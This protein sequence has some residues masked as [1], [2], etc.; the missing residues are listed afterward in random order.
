MRWAKLMALTWVGLLA[1][2]KSEQNGQTGSVGVGAC[3][4]QDCARRGQDFL[5]SINDQ[6]VPTYVGAYCVEPSTERAGFA[7]WGV[8]TCQCM[9]ADGTVDV[10]DA[11]VHATAVCG[12]GGNGGG[13][14]GIGGIGSDTSIGGGEPS[15]DGTSGGRGG[16]GGSDA[17]SGSDTCIGG[18]GGGGRGNTLGG[19]AS[20]DWPVPTEACAAWGRGRLACVFP[21]SARQNC[22]TSDPHSCDVVCAQLQQGYAEDAARD[23]DVELRSSSC[24]SRRPAK[25]GH[26]AGGGSAA[27]E[28][29]CV[30]VAR[31]GNGCYITDI[32]DNFTPPAYDCSLTD[33]EI[34]Q[35][36]APRYRFGE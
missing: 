25:S 21:F 4:Q 17:S 9:K 20:S 22:S 23:Y 1:C 26:Y 6:G 12:P 14:G 13:I 3:N 16:I 19:V 29:E 27:S 36:D 35:R 32:S 15:G 2:S 30:K 24:R 8:Q 11:D 28:P 33:D 5:D 7:D 18:S 34:L 10:V 31:I